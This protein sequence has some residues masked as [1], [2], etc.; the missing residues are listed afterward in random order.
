MHGLLLDR[1]RSST[2]SAGTTAKRSSTGAGG[3]SRPALAGIV[4]ARRG[5][6]SAGWRTCCTRSCVTRWPA[7][8]RQQ[9]EGAAPP[10]AHRW[11]RSRCSSR[12]GSR[13]A[14]TSRPDHGAGRARAAG[15]SPPSSPPATSRGRRARQMP[16]EEKIARSDFVFENRGGA[17]RAPGTSSGRPWRRSS[18]P[19]DRRGG[20][21]G[22]SDFMKRMLSSRRVV[23]AAGGPSGSPAGR[24]PPRRQRRPGLVRKHRVSPGARRRHPRGAPR[25]RRPGAGRRG[26]LRRERVRRA[27]GLLAGRN[28]AHAGAARD[29]AQIAR[30]TGGR[31][32]RPDL[33]D[34]RS[35]CATGRTTCARRSTSSTATASPPGRVQ[36]R[37]GAVGEWRRRRRAGGPPMRA[38]RHPVP[39]DT[40]L[41]KRGARGAQAL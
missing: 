34:P 9:K 6:A 21:A 37:R 3:I 29:G 38:P 35:T 27:R 30:R 28:R 36:C 22:E 25:Q 23:I 1:P 32:S 18:P 17:Q 41:R 5:R 19:S 20:G 12:R 2:S 39:G 40:G 10:G 31:A 4:F 8:S 16:E 26:D 14:S 7:G 11:S 15:A 13:R 24:R 33:E